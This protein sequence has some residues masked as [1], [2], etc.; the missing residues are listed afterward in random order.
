MDKLTERALRA[1]HEVESIHAAA[2]AHGA[3]V[4]RQRAHRRRARRTGA[5]LAT[6]MAIVAPTIIIVANS[7]ISRPT[8]SRAVFAGPDRATGEAASGEKL[9]PGP[10]PPSTKCSQEPLPFRST[11]VPPGWSDDLQVGEL[12]DQKADGSYTTETTK[13]WKGPAGE[14]IGVFRDPPGIEPPKDPQSMT[15]LGGRGDIGYYPL[16]ASRAEENSVMSAAF[17]WCGSRWALVGTGGASLDDVRKL[18]EGL[19]PIES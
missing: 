1:R 10:V 2:T 5:L 3:S 8:S 12:R 19:V 18:A 7:E 16:P 11:Y 15:V 9:Q 14:A 17:S 13:S 4:I 6:G